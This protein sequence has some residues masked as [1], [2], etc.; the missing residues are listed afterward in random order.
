MAWLTGMSLALSLAAAGLPADETDVLVRCGDA[1]VR[2]F[3]L[4][5]VV[6]RL[7]LAGAADDPQ[8]QRAEAAIL[9]QLVDE[10]IL[11]AELERLGILATGPE[12]EASVTRLKEQVTA[13]GLVFE[14]FLAATGRTPR[15]LDAQVALEIALDKFVRPQ[16]TAAALAE[17]FDR[18]RRELDG[19]LLRVSHILLRPE[20]GG[21]DDAT[22]GLLDRAA[23]I[24]QQIVQGRLSFADAARFHSA[25]PSR[26][27]GGDLGWIG[28]EGPMLEGF[29]SRAYTLSKGVV[30][31]PFASPQGVHIVTV[32]AV[33]PGRLE[34]DAVRPKLEKILAQKLVRG[35]VA[36]GRQR[37]PVRFSPGVPHFDPST[38]D[39]PIDERPVIVAAG[40]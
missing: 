30:S 14:N 32:T 37:V 36:A 19:T 29:A 15:D 8:R 26:R 13:R 9:E 22:K 17:T 39:R 7:G 4:E 18:N 20:A 10:R 25:G 38:A 28:R 1:A 11:R 27:Q 23:V 3:D 40:G 2:R 31:A 33:Q 6:E 34:I 5:R 12:I 21:P 35:L 24:R 16:L